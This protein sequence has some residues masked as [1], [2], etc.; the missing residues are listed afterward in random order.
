MFSVWATPAFARWTVVPVVAKLG[1]WFKRGKGKAAPSAGG[2]TGAV[3]GGV[4]PKGS[5]GKS[6]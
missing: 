4:V 6:Q 1:K 2:G 3:D 5:S